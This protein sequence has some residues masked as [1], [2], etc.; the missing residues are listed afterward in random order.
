MWS[1][2]PSRSDSTYCFP[3]LIGMVAS[4]PSSSRSRAW[5]PSRNLKC[6]RGEH[7]PMT[8]RSVRSLSR[9]LALIRELNVSGPLSVLQLAQ[10][11]GLHRT[12]CYRLLETLQA[13]G[14]VTF[15][16]ASALFGLTAQV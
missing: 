9:G 1:L 11:S 2:R 3:V 5:L 16:R 8:H 13:D 14:F 4:W 12:T 7:P 6:S 10:R 15:D